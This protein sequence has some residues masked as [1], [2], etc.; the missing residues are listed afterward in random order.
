MACMSEIK[1]QK[2]PFL[3]LYV[4]AQIPNTLTASIFCLCH[5]PTLIPQISWRKVA[6]IWKCWELY[7]HTSIMQCSSQC[8]NQSLEKISV[9]ARLCY[10][11]NVQAIITV[12][13]ARGLSL[14]E[15]RILQ[16]VV[17]ISCS[18]N[19]LAICF[20]LLYTICSEITVQRVLM[21]LNSLYY[22][23]AALVGLQMYCVQNVRNPTE[24]QLSHT[25]I[26]FNIFW[27]ILCVYQIADRQLNDKL[28]RSVAGHELGH[29]G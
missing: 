21:S 18:H 27:A 13:H 15:A 19:Q 9:S 2:Q 16:E 11:T 4:W 1:V 29:R 24:W 7:L 5:L 17:F 28:Q 23:A 20:L 25:S 8:A 10:T 3:D 6:Y 14:R 22:C 26:T 12:I